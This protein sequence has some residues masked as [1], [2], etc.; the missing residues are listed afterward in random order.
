MLVHTLSSALRAF[1]SIVLLSTTSV[2]FQVSPDSPCSS[3]CTID[4][5]V[6]TNSTEIVCADADFSTTT[7]GLRFKNCV[8]CLQTSPYFSGTESDVKWFLCKPGL[9]LTV[10]D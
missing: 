1:L 8:D 4:G 2:A 6:D 3:Q 7:T 9:D 5:A 10:S